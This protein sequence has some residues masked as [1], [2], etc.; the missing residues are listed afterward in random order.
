VQRR[1]P[2]DDSKAQLPP[3]GMIFT[4]ADPRYTRRLDDRPGGDII[5]AMERVRE[6]IPFNAELADDS[7]W[8]WLTS[9]SQQ[10]GFPLRSA[11]GGEHE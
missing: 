5:V 4:K 3:F 7:A 6:A 10:M 2:N 1:E 8:L 9:D 11:G